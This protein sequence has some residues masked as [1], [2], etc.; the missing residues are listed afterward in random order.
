MD[1]LSSFNTYKLG[2]IIEVIKNNK[3]FIYLNIVLS[4]SSIYN[5]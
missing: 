2:H 3:N 4:L 1:E 5:Q